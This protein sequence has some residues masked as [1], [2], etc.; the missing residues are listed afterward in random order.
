MRTWPVTLGDR[1]GTPQP[2]STRIAQATW[3][4]T[5]PLLLY[6][7]RARHTR[8]TY[9]ATTSL[10]LWTR[11]VRATREY[12]YFH[13]LAIAHLSPDLDFTQATVR[14]HYPGLLQPRMQVCTYFIALCA[15]TYPTSREAS[16]RK[17]TTQ[18]CLFEPMSKLH[19]GTSQ[20]ASF[21]LLLTSV[22]DDLESAIWAPPTLTSNISLSLAASA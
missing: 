2:L 11:D 5:G 18:T 7:D 8:R 16:T 22:P 15:Q 3:K 13:R 9:E 10:P 12:T 17:L 1:I 19:L 4:H 14:G 20:L 6:A 21:L